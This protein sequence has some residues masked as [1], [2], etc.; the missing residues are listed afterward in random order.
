[1]SGNLRI[2]EANAIEDEMELSW[3]SMEDKMIRELPSPVKKKYYE[4]PVG[5]QDTVEIWALE[6]GQFVVFYSP[7]G[8][9][10]LF[11]EWIKAKNF[12][13]IRAKHL[14]VS[15]RGFGWRR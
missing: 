9:M 1:M 4:K 6:N 11:D 13:N 2:A 5:Y 7:T 10:F 8:A 3:Q 12:R 14:R 15:Y